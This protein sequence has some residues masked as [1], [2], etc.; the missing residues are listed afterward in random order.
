[1][2]NILVKFFGFYA[3]LIHGDT[4]VLDRW[5]WLKKRLPVT[6]EDKSML[7]VGCGSGA[8]T[9]GAAIRGYSSLGLSWDKRNQSIAQERAEILN[10]KNAK[11]EVCDV[12]QLDQQKIYIDKFDVV[13]NFEN[14]EHI[15]NDK[16]LI[17]DIEKCL[18]PGGKFYM[19]TPNFYY[20]PMTKED[21]G[22][23]SKFED[24]GHVRR[25]YT[26]QMLIELCDA[27]GL[28][29]EEISYCSGF[30][31]QKTT[32]LFRK[33]SN[34]NFLFAWAFILP[35]RPFIPILDKFLP[36]RRYSI[37]LEAYKPKY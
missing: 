14:I 7:D 12:R 9:F 24:G 26:K 5:L 4:L 29:I 15:L 19:T 35:I 18:K 25:G 27:A 31:S 13:I 36:Y 11:F 20:I 22:P 37:C 2:N 10:L 33:L 28:K 8:F 17:L 21:N 6:F 34:I 23:F 16:K 3:T 32:F 1:M 30:F